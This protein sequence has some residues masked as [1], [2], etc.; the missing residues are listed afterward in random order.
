M[1]LKIAKTTAFVAITAITL[2]AANYNAQA[3]KDRIELEKYTVAKFDE[4]FK[5]K[6][7]FFP[8]SGDEELQKW[9][10]NIPAENFKDGSYSYNLTGKMTRDGLMEM[11]PFEENIEIGEVLYNKHFKTCFPDPT[12]AG[13]YPIFDEKS[14][15]TI[16]LGEALLSCA[17]KAKLKIGK[18][19]WDLKSKKMA[20]LQS[21]IAL[22]SQEAG[23]KMNIKIESA[24]AAKAYENGKHEFYAQRGYL[25]LSCAS[26]HVQGA[27]QRVRLEFMSPITGGVTHFPSYR[28]SKDSLRTLETRLGGCNRNMGEVPHKAGSDWSSDVLY[29]MAYMSNGMD[30]SGPDVRK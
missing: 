3:E 14:K 20:N 22:Q 19:H 6:Y 18:K 5:N 2:N 11:P 26:C 15:S 4:P 12:T 8:Y 30:L 1:L 29:F 13:D 21:F 9:A 16:T 17:K 23:K 28:I 10:K 25:E 27:G 7:T 24:D